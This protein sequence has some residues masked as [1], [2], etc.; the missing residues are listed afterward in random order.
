MMISTQAADDDHPLSLLI[1]DGLASG[2]PAVVVHLLAAP[3]DADPFDLETIRAVNPALGEFL[4]ESDLVRE[5]E[6][7]RRIPAFMPAFENLRLNRRIDAEAERRIVTREVW[8]ACGLPVDIEALR[9]RPCYGALD[10]SGKHDLTSL[11]AGVS[12]RPAG[13]GFRRPAVLLD[14]GE[15]TERRNPREKELFGQW[16]RAG[17][18]TAIPG[19]TIRYR[20]VAAELARL[21]ELYDIQAIAYDRWRID[22]FKADMA[23]V[24]LELPLE[25][26]GQGFKDLAPAVEFFAELALTGRLRHGGHPV[27]TSCV[28]NAI[29]VTDPAG[30]LKIDKGRS[31]RPG[32]VRIDGAVTLVMALGLAKRFEAEPA[33]DVLSMVI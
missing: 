26:F 28:A 18:I 13:A 25:E 11:D 23:D 2:D 33:F 19:P 1:D 29:T 3:P 17:L 9:G 5:A 16:I 32:M 24:G 4:D 10:L 14:A 12:R 20:T 21:K 22:D 8:E 15:A 31:N 6:M 30:N 7:A 27:L